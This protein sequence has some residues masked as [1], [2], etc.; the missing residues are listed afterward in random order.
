MPI[1]RLQPEGRLSG[2]VAHGDTFHLAGRIADADLA[3]IAAMNHTIAVL[4]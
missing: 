3:A 1:R 4:P 2:A